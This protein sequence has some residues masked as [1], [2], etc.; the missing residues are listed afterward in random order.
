MSAAKLEFNI[1]Q[2]A[3]FKRIL[4]FKDSDG[5]LIDL[6]GVVLRGQIRKTATD[7]T[8]I[9]SFTCVVDP[10]Q[11]TNKGQATISL[12]ATQTSAIAVDPQKFAERKPQKYA[13]DLEKVESDTVTVVRVLEGIVNVSPEVTK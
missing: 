8:I 7:S 13:Y 2:G 6:T 12:T 9:S 10:D 4:V 3:T 1:E 11:I 5:V